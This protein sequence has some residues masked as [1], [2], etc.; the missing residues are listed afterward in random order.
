MIITYDDF[1]GWYDHQMP[2]IVSSSFSPTLVST[3]LNIP[4]DTLNGFAI[5]NKG[6]Q[7]DGPARGDAPEKRIGSPAWGR[8]GYGTSRWG[9]KPCCL[10]NAISSTTALSHQTSSAS[11][12]ALSAVQRAYQLGGSLDTIAGKLDHMF[13]FSQG[14]RD[15]RKLILN[16]TTGTVV[17]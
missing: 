5:C 16:P 1:D 13:D 15:S 9:C 4:T 10:P 11:S 3:T 7:Q 2:P 17:F 14:D 6:L 8:C 12:K